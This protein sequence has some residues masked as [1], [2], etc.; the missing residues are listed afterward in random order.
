MTMWQ[1]G[2]SSYFVWL[3][4]GKTSVALD[5][6]SDAGRERLR[7]LMSGADVVVQNLRHGALER[8]GFS[9]ED[10]RRENPRLITCSITGFDPDGDMAARKA[11]DLLIQ[12]ESG[13]CSITGGPDEP[14][15]VGVSVVDI[16]TGRNR[17][18]CHSRGTD[19]AW[20]HG[21]GNGDHGVDV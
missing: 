5:L 8:L 11:Y 6:T 7:D 9:F 16:A 19:R 1:L 3:N 13:L 14:S 10:L 17:A 4:R 15:R 21:A 2:Q 18:F 12:A 20:Y